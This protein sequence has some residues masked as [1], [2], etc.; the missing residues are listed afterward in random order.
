MEQEKNLFSPH[1]AADLGNSRENVENVQDKLRQFDPTAKVGFPLVLDG[2]LQ[3]WWKQKANWKWHSD[4]FFSGSETQQTFFP[5]M[6]SR[7]FFEN[8]EKNSN[9]N[10]SLTRV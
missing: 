2:F 7:K 6:V 1:I 10:Y 4:S 8:K 3:R 5:D 9:K